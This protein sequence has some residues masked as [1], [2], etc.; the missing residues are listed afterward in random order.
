MSESDGEASDLRWWPDDGPAVGDRVT[1][2]TVSHNTR[3]LLAFLLWS[4]HRHIAPHVVQVVVVDNDST[5]GSRE[6]VS[7]CAEAGLCDLI[8]N[9]VNRYHGPGLNQVASHVA[10]QR[11]RG[12]EVGWLWLLD[13]DCVI[14]RS[15]AVTAALA[16]AR[17]TDALLVG[18]PR[19]DP[20][21]R[22]QRL[23]TFSLLFDPGGVW[24]PPT[25]AFLEDG[26]PARAFELS[27]RQQGLPI[28]EF[29][30]AAGGYV[31]HRGRGTL[32]NVKERGDVANR[33]HDWA[34]GHHEAHYE[35]VLDA[36]A[37]HRELWSEFAG[38]VGEITPERFVAALESG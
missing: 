28:A 14:A 37:R 4:V 23:S 38:T 32:A 35:E 34:D 30:F 6:L 7:A 11:S 22:E 19:W 9:P 24:R 26:D 15:D 18:E 10:A 3:E 21:H 13:S 12:E 20:W 8:A 17:R 16:G 29:P 36:E 25:S 27:C 2:G 1:V 5:D 33:Y 31:I